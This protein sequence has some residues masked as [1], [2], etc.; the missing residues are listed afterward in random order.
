MA[1]GLPSGVLN[2]L[3]GPTPPA[4]PGLTF[5]VGHCENAAALR[6]LKTGAVIKPAQSAQV[7]MLAA[8]L[9]SVAWGIYEFSD[10]RNNSGSLAIFAAIRRRASSS[11]TTCLPSESD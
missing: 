7:A 2:S 6:S 11:S 5:P 3:A 1:P 9:W 10:L 4:Q 8:R